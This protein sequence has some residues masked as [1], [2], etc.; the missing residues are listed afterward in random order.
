MLTWCIMICYCIQIWICVVFFSTYFVAQG[1]SSVYDVQDRRVAGCLSVS[2]SVVKYI[3]CCL[4][5]K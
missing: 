5:F 3:L 2:V 4:L 1:T